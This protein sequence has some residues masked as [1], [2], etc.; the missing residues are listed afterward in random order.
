MKKI[1][2]FVLG[3]LMATSMMAQGDKEAYTVFDAAGKKLTYYY[4]DQSESREGVVELL[5]DKNRWADYYKQV[6]VIVIITGVACSM[7]P[8]CSRTAA[9]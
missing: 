2:T 6:T 5:S 9:N 3:C 8:L 4:D 7:Q 1:F